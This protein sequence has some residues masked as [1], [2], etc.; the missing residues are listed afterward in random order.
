M[1]DALSDEDD[2]A[3]LVAQLSTPHGDP[4][5]DAIRPPAVV[6]VTRSDVVA[7]GE[8]REVALVDRR[9]RHFQQR[10]DDLMHHAQ[11]CKKIKRFFHFFR[12]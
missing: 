1:Q 8:L 4:P 12:L 6:V 11:T 3:S 10:S 7:L 5:P 2:L 9:K